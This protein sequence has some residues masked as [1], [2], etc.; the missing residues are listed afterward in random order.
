[1]EN[2]Q[3]KFDSYDYNGD[4]KNNYFMPEFKNQNLKGNTSFLKWNESMK[5]IYGKNGFL[6]KCSKDYIFFYRSIEECNRY[7]LY[8]VNC[9]VCKQY[10]CFYCHRYVN[11][12]F[13]ENGTCCLKRK[14][15]CMFNQDC[16]RYINPIHNEPDI[17]TFT[18]AFIQFI[19][20]ILH[21]LVLI[22]QIQGIFYY[23][24][25]IKEDKI[26]DTSC[27]RYY[28]HISVYD[29]VVILNIGIA[30][31]LVIPL[32]FTHIIFIIAMIIISLPFKFIPLKYILGIH[33]A[34]INFLELFL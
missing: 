1:M 22:T 18:A 15:K 8:Q 19:I 2:E 34:T 7:P 30:F 5:K 20:P 21:L 13:K 6:F 14:I 16:Y 17:N 27:V 31:L 12:D 24:L 23:K 25:A 28:D 11:D 3:E 26:I 4:I 33:F 32:F 9:P 10:I 29:K